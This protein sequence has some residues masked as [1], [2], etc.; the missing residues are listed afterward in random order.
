[1]PFPVGVR[2]PERIL[3]AV[4]LAIATISC[5][6]GRPPSVSVSPAADLGAAQDAG[7]RPALASL[8]QHVTS[9]TASRYGLADSEGNSMDTLKVIDG[10]PGLYLGV[11]HVLERGSF[12][13]KLAT[14]NDLVDWTFRT[15][16]AAHGSQPT[17]AALADGGYVVAYE[18]NADCTGLGRWPHRSCLRFLYYPSFPALLSA[19]ASR[20]FR[21]PRTLSRCNEGTPSL[22][23]VRLARDIDHSTISVAFH[24]HRD[25][26]VDRQARGTLQ[27]FRTWSARAVPGLDRALEAFGI[28]GNI[29]DRDGI[30]YRGTSYT[31]L[32][33]ERVHHVWSSWRCFL[34]DA[35]SGE[36]VELDLRT[37]GNSP[38]CANPIL[39]LVDA[40]G[41]GSAVVVAVFI[42]V[43]GA[44]PG[45]AGELLYYIDL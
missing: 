14:S 43:E 45:E 30:V 9:A 8:I 6:T 22:Q 44:A 20:T 42:P 41:G 15:D 7:P 33:G 17:I 18:S 38:A 37:R 1:M 13:V 36:I 25:C 28:R 23:A 27:D 5:S 10:P 24:Y 34:E 12:T 31:I 19:A 35:S 26:A 16:L 40:P 2:A 4:L 21:A 39:T 3:I 11:Y 29:G 32:E